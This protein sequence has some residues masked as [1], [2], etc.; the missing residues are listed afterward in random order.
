MSAKH[1]FMDI[2]FGVSEAVLPYISY[3]NVT[4]SI[5]FLTAKLVRKFNFLVEKKPFFSL[6]S[7]FPK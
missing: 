2:F 4:A 5:M 1:Y 3:F 6:A 7:Q